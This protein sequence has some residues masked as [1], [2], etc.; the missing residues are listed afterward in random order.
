MKKISEMTEEEVRDYAL[1]LEQERDA[2][3]QV[4]ADKDKVISDLKDDVV[5]L[6]RRNNKLFTQVEQQRINP[7]PADPAPEEDAE[8]L[9]DYAKN[10]YKEFI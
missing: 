9:E 1:Q 4:M 5:S 7:A 3:T 6:Q 8:S 10:K 2:N